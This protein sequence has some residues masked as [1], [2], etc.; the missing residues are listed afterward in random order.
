M[1]LYQ[2]NFFIGIFKH[3]K[4]DYRLVKILIYSKQFLVAASVN[5]SYFSKGNVI[6]ETLGA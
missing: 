5:C 2:N 1:Q 3:F 6:L 4:N